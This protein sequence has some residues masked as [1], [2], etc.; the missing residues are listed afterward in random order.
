MRSRQDKVKLVVEV[1]SRV[2]RLPTAPLKKVGVVRVV[3]VLA[4]N[5]MVL[6]VPPV[7]ERP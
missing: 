3:T 5:F 7:T 6:V 1:E 4:V 2:I